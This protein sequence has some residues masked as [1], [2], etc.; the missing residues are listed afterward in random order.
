MGQA[1]WQVSQGMQNKVVAKSSVS[2]DRFPRFESQ[3][4]HLALDF[5][6]V[7]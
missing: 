5:G 1:L 7:T 2:G 4:C 6:Q 3:F